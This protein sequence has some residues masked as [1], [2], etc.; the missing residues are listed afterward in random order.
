MT[1]TAH[2]CGSVIGV[3]G[4]LSDVSY[5]WSKN[6]VAGGVRPTVFA[7]FF[8]TLVYLLFLNGRTRV[9]QQTLAVIVGIMS[10]CFLVNPIFVAP[11]LGDVLKGLVPQVPEATGGR[12]AFLVIASM[13][14][15]TVFS[16]LFILRGS[17]VRDAGWTLADYRMQ[18]RDA[19]ISAALMFLCERRRDGCRGR[20]AARARAAP[21]QRVGDDRFAGAARGRVRG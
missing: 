14:G 11:P 19:A 4:I 5:E 18:R 20:V 16:G 8:I 12:S 17:L 3:M 15:T 10:I 1:L 2:V 21:D 9:F 13:V 7:V 6:F